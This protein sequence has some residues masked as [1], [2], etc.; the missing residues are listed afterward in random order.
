VLL[1]RSSGAAAPAD[2]QRARLRPRY[3]AGSLF[4]WGSRGCLL[5]VIYVILTCRLLP[6]GAGR[7]LHFDAQAA[8]G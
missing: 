3:L 2:G 1:T 8:W 6:G 5:C 7:M 4:R